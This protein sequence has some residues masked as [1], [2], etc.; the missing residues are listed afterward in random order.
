VKSI[1][2]STSPPAALEMFDTAAPHIIVGDDGWLDIDAPLDRS[3]YRRIHFP[4]NLQFAGNTN[5]TVNCILKEI[6]NVE[7][8]VIVNTD[9]QFTDHS[10]ER[11]VSTSQ[12]LDAIVGPAIIVPPRFIRD[13][14]G[15]HKQM[16]SPLG[17]AT[18]TTDIES[19]SSISGC[20]MAVPAK[21]WTSVGGF[22]SDNFKA[23]YE[24]D[25][26]CVRAH[27]SGLDVLV[28]FTALVLH[29][30]NQT[31]RSVP[32]KKDLIHNSKNA[33]AAK[34][35]EITQ[36]YSGRYYIPPTLN[37]YDRRIKRYHRQE[38]LNCREQ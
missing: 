10:L 17:Y 8:L 26:L 18:F 2:E 11:I 37:E 15:R 30:V 33:F 16:F 24:D 32:N 20:C 3:G 29:E 36:D 4:T 25:D 23:F 13:E 38:E 19:L 21:W 7:T 1:Y 27:I 5:R 22:D 6:N 28:D 34:W 9:V 12:T 14:Y 35:P 31:M